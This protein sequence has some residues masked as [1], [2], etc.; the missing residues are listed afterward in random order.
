MPISLAPASQ[1]AFDVL[2]AAFNT[3][4][5]GYIVPVNLT[6]DQFRTHLDHYDI[7]LDASCIAVLG[8]EVVGAALLGRRETR[9]WVGGI[10]IAPAHRNRGIGRQLMTALL[11]AARASG[12]KTVQLEVII[13]NDS[14]YHLYQTLGFQ[15]V[16]RLLILELAPAQVVEGSAQTTQPISPVEALAHYERL[17]S[18]PNPWQRERETLLKMAHQL[19]GWIASD[20]G[21]VT[22]YGVAI[23]QVQTIRWL[24]LA[25]ENDEILREM[26][27][28]VHGLQPAATARFVNLAEDDSVWHPLAVLGY[29]EVMS[30]WEMELAL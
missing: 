22:A 10:G 30:Q 11:D 2:F 25:G 26:V 5:Q 1:I 15:T 20:N 29:S 21:Q 6:A 27:A 13:G 9:G 19:S 18:T 7:D 24:D 16:R 3:G 23:V 14:A 12:L 4:Y 8:D 28:Y 17:H